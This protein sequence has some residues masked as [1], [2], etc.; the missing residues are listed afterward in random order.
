MT[1]KINK[2]RNKYIKVP[3]KTKLAFLREVLTEGDEIKKVF[4]R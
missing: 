4:I 3:L 1:S 2:K